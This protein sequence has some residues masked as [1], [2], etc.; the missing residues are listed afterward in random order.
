MPATRCLWTGPLDRLFQVNDHAAGEVPHE[1]QGAKYSVIET[2]HRWPVQQR[3]APAQTGSD[4]IRFCHHSGE[5]RTYLLNLFPCHRTLA[6]GVI[7]LLRT[8]QF[9]YFGITHMLEEESSAAW[10]EEPLDFHDAGLQ[11]DMMENP[12]SVDHIEGIIWKFRGVATHQHGID[13]IAHAVQSGPLFRKLNADGRNVN[14]GHVSAQ[15]GE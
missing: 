9:D 5:F 10:L 6:F 15:L 8:Q 2:L 7:L 14:R 11:T 13:A 3:D 4:V 12:E 1:R